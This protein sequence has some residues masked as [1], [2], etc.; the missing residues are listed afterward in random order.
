LT[1]TSASFIARRS[2]IYGEAACNCLAQVLI[3]AIFTKYLSVTAPFVVTLVVVIQKFYLRTSRQV[4]LLDIETKAPVYLQFLETTSGATTIRA[5]G[6]QHQ[7]Q[8]SLD[9]ILDWSRRPVYLLYCVQQW[10]AFI[11]DLLVAALAIILVT[12]VVT[13][14]TSFDPGAVGLSLV[15]VMSFNKTLMSVVKYWTM[16][17]TSVGAVT[18]IKDFVEMTES[19]EHNNRIVESAPQDWPASGAVRFSNLV[20]SPA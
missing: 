1:A 10:L 2:N 16:L 12:I 3:L 8:Q 9:S 14:R 13:W 4:R 7:F 15:L 11:L 5:F 18:R 6:W 19:E 17:E 20:A